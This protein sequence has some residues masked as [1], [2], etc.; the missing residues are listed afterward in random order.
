MSKK[1]VLVIDPFS[2]GA[3]FAC[4]IRDIYGY[5]AIALI[6]NQSLPD[7]VMST[8]RKEDYSEVFYMDEFYNTASLIESCIG[9]PPSYIICGSEP[10]VMV[11]DRLC[12]LWDLPANDISLSESRRNKFQMQ[13]RIK[14]SG[15]KYIPFFKSSSKGKIID[16]C[17]KNK[18]SE[19]VIKPINSFGT[20]GVYFCKN[21]Q[22]VE[23]AFSGLINTHDYS[24]NNNDELLIE[25]KIDGTEYVVDVVSCAGK[26]FAVN[27]FRYVKEEVN[28]IPIYKQMIT[29]SVSDHPVLVSYV[30]DV[31][32]SLGINYGASHNEIIMTND[33]PV[34]VESGARM[35]GGLGPRLVE[36]CNSHS[37]I[38]LSI[39]ARISSNDFSQQTSEPPILKKYATEYFLS[40]PE[41]GIVDAVNIEALCKP[42]PS[43]SFT[44]CKLNRGDYVSKTVD[45]ITSYG[46]IVLFNDD[47]MLMEADVRKIAEL[48]S[49]GKLICIVTSDLT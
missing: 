12:D 31:L 30:Y 17:M 8:F 34:L 44:T 28:Q 16:W 25:Q 36:E 46:R 19:Y 15:L 26:H 21:L 42:F 37:L 18:F 48:E 9:S 27:I 24:G 4:R 6:T 22:D 1:Y 45:L 23:L 35:H 20:E 32:S 2:S 33:G 38:D 10:G 13:K 3:V 47:R 14:E 5:D 7:A 43:Y 11:F 40:S 49:S 41:S 39:I 29:E